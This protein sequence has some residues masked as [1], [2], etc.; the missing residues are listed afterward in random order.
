MLDPSYAFYSPLLMDEPSQQLAGQI[1][2]RLQDG[3][4]MIESS[5][6]RLHCRRAASCLLTP[7]P[8]DTVLVTK[9]AGQFWV[10]AILER[11][12]QQSAEI[13]VSGDLTIA[14]KGNLTLNSHEL[15]VDANSGNC[16]I[17]KMQYMGESL[18]AWVSITQFI[19]NKLESVWQTVTQLSHRLFRHTAQTE[20][21]RAGQLDIQTENY[22]RLH[23]KNTIIS[24]KA[25]TK[26]DAE[27]IHI[28]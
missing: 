11:P 12:E 6:E 14:S 23:A 2:R 8:E 13:S 24:A 22:L 21:V 4:F 19:G 1:I 27:Q 17:K 7:E 15:N 5:G 10:L 16:Q 26:I 3:S 28:G 9:V 25:I 18:Y 20:Q